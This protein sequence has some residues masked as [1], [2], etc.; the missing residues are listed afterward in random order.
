MTKIPEYTK[1]TLFAK[2]EGDA[3]WKVIIDV[4]IPPMSSQAEAAGHPKVVAR[5]AAL[6][7][8]YTIIEMKYQTRNT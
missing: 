2:N 1:V 3:T 4:N 7:S 5:R 8:R 6:D